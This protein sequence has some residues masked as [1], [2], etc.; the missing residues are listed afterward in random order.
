MFEFEVKST[1]REAIRYIAERLRE[2]QIRRPVTH[3]LEIFGRRMMQRLIKN[4]P[5]DKSP[6]KDEIVAREHWQF[7][8]ITQPFHYRVR[9]TNDVP[10]AHALEFGSVPGQK[11]WPGVGP[12]T[13]Y[14]YSQW[15]YETMG[16][17]G[18]FIMSSQAQYGMAA[19]S[20]KEAGG[21]SQLGKTIKEEIERSM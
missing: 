19:Q 11:P 5:I 21:P 6:T 20:L 7:D 17:R 18:V 10:Y 3:A 14:G 1:E 9:F 12:R 8:I 16:T 2:A 15:G 13:T 4:T